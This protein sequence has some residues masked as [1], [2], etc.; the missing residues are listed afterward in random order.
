MK[1]LDLKGSSQ[2]PVSVKLTFRKDPVLKLITCI[3]QLFLPLFEIFKCQQEFI[4]QMHSILE[5]FSTN[6]FQM[7]IMF[8]LL[9]T[10]Y[11][12]YLFQKVFLG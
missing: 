10:Y 6:I 11:T 12:Q 9:V 5:S 8:L 4:L 7:C 1:Y 3:N 2:D